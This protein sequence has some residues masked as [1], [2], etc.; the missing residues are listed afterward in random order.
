[1]TSNFNPSGRFNLRQLPRNVWVLTAVSFLT[2]VST[3]MIVHLIPLFLAN[4]LG[5]KTNLIGLIEGVA[6]MT[7]SLVKVWAGR[8]SDQLGQRKWL[9]A[10][11][12]TLSTL[13]KPFLVL[14]TGWPAV[15]L[16]RFVERMGKGLRTAPRDALVA[17]VVTPETRGLAFGIHRAGD[18]AG[19]MLGLLMALALVWW[20]QGD[21][22][23]LSLPTFQKVVWVSFIP[24]ALAVLLLLWGV[25]EP[26]KPPAQTSAPTLSLTTF[27][28][29]FQKY[30]AIVVLFTLGNSSD[31]FLVLRAQ[32]RGVNLISILAIL[33]LFNFISAAVSGPAGSLS[34]RLGRRQLLVWGW[35]IYALIYLGF[36]LAQTAT[37]ITLLFALYGFYYGLT[38]GATKAFVADLV[39]PEQRGTAY[40][41]FHAAVGLTALPASLLAGILWQGVG[42]FAGF[43]PAAPFYFGAGAA[44]LAVLLLLWLVPNGQSEG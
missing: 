33:G 1:M 27:S 29:T 28:P 18:T 38:S 10:G 25:T 19:A 5:V 3:E 22:L 31:A 2:D 39:R 7:S 8:L 9:T 41:L 17:D 40:G 13:A 21:A 30:V 26:A 44:G 36:A 23:Q 12:Y 42:S 4:V 43:G 11:G 15:L 37:H 24:A 14:A 34:D 32:E 6:E 20:W 16:I 35:L